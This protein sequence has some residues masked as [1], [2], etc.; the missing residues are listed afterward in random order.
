MSGFWIID[1]NLTET[2]ITGNP[3]MS[4]RTLE[5]LMEMFGFAVSEVTEPQPVEPQAAEPRGD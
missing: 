1:T 3:N 2:H 5:L 4:E